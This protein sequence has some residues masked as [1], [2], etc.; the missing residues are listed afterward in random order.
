MNIK[1]EHLTKQFD[2]KLYAV[3]DISFEENVKDMAIIGPSGCG[4]ST[5]LRL[6]GG[7]ITKTSGE[8]YL[9]DIKLP[10]VE[11]DLIEYRKNIGFVF[12]QGGL[13]NHM[14]ALQNIAL[15]LVKVHGWSNKDAEETAFE[16]LKRF[17][18]ENH[19]H[20]RPVA[21]SGGQRQR[22]SIARAIAP[23][24]KLLLFDEPTSALD[25]EYTAEVLD[26]ITELKHQEMDFIIVTHEMGFAR[27]ACSKLAFMYEGKI[28]EY[29]ASQDLFNN[30]STPEFQQFLSKLLAWS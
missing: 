16:L 7:L 29:G 6:I 24:P 8:L 1:L 10:I 4:K 22:I 19:A 17:N 3:N 26:M 2:D 15:P 28:L 18:L 14:T 12:Q 21:L 25:P 5:L 27:H 9:S 20:K 23:K 13:F 11:K 30:Q